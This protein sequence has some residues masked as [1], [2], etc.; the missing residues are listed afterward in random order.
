MR[1]MVFRSNT[2]TFTF[3][4][5]SSGG[6][7]IYIVNNPTLTVTTAATFS[8][9][10]ITQTVGVNGAQT[11]YKW[12]FTS[13]SKL[14]A[15]DYFKI[16]PPSTISFSSSPSWTGITGLATSLSWSY[17]SGALYI[18]VAFSRRNLASGDPG[19]YALTVS[20]ITNAPSTY[21]STAFT[22]QS[23][24]SDKTYL[25]EQ[26]TTVTVTNSAAG[27]IT[28]ASVSPNSVSLSTNV[29]YTLTFTPVNYYQGMTLKITIPSDLSISDGTQTCVNVKGFVDSSFSCT[30]TSSSR[31][32]VVTGEFTGSS[33]PGEVSLQMPNIKNPSSYLTTNSFFINTYITI[34][35][36]NYAIDSL[37]SGLT[38]SIKWS[39]KWLTWGSSASYCLT[40][41]TSS[42]YK[43]LLSN[44]CL[45]SCP[46]GYYSNV[47]VCS[48]WDSNWKTWSGSA[49]TWISC[50]TSMY[51]YSS[52]WYST[53]PTGYVASGSTWVLYTASSSSSQTILFPFLI[54]WVVVTFGVLII[55]WSK[56]ETRFLPSAIALV[57]LVELTSWFYLAYI[58]YNNSYTVSMVI[59]GLGIAGAFITNFIFISIYCSSISIDKGFKPYKNKKRWW[60]WFITTI[61]MLYWHRFFRLAYSHIAGANSLGGILTSSLVSVRILSMIS[62]WISSLPV[63]LS[64]GYNIL[65]ASFGDQVF[66]S[67]VENIII[68]SYSIIL[69]SIEMA[70]IGQYKLPPKQ[71]PND[72]RLSQSGGDIFSN[73]SKHSDIDEQILRKKALDRILKNLDLKHQGEDMFG[74]KIKED[75][76]NPHMRYSIQEPKNKFDPDQKSDLDNRRVESEPIMKHRDYEETKSQ[77]NIEDS[78]DQINAKQNDKSTRNKG[79]TSPKKLTKDKLFT[80]S[81]AKK[82]T[83]DGDNDETKLQDKDDKGSKNSKDNKNLNDGKIDED[84]AFNAIGD[85]SEEEKKLDFSGNI[86]F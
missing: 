20:G 84:D 62:I 42:S 35:G 61:S 8:A 85:Q 7:G 77:I 83:K 69:I 13:T 29:S 38:A 66:Y 63:I 70:K 67:D 39:S 10:T 76:N 33:N 53:W 56:K 31:E 32:I 43:Y 34:S 36:T 72:D 21:P 79:F 12:T 41:D 59:V 15:G 60:H 25:I 81:D 18:T 46:D 6:Y 17:S 75:E 16:V 19:S 73:I 80:Q 82:N 78:L 57:C 23:Y 3:E 30:Y 14:T 4:F 28:S 86:E 5:K 71:N 54:A 26:S 1:G 40:C 47:S 68:S 27:T 55:K 45:T 50:A 52:K 74:E 64:W 44:D 51:L 9:M 2:G 11:S 37:T 24:L 58:F 48:I 22:F 65:Y 49:T